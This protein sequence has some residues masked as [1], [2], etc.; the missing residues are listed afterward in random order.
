MCLALDQ[1]EAQPFYPGCFYLAGLDTLVLAGALRSAVAGART[2]VDAARAK[3]V[4]A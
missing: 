2:R 1:A 4:G 3:A